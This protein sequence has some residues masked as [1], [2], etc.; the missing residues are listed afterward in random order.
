MPD[1]EEVV[2]LLRI[3]GHVQ[4]V[5]YR[6]SAQAEAVRL[7]LRGWVRNRRDGRVE[8]VAQ[9]PADAV[10]ALIDWAQHGPAQARVTRVAVVDAAPEAFDG[11]LTINT[12]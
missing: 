10:Q 1:D 6:A 11:F 5:W 7:G 3:H 12:V 9:G 4:G 2:R 8:A